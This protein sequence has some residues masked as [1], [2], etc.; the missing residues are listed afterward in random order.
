MLTDWDWNEVQNTNKHFIAFRY[1]VRVSDDLDLQMDLRSTWLPFFFYLLSF[2]PFYVKLY[3][4]FL[5]QCLQ[6]FRRW[7]ITSVDTTRGLRV[8][9]EET[10]NLVSTET[11][12]LT[13]NTTSVSTT[14]SI[15]AECRDVVLGHWF[16]PFLSVRNILGPGLSLEGQVT[17]SGLG[18][19]DKSSLTKMSNLDPVTSGMPRLTR[20]REILRFLLDINYF[21]V[22]SCDHTTQPIWV[23][24]ID[25]HGYNCP[26]RVAKTGKIPR[27]C[28]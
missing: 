9:L 4:H 26:I 5:S 25:N 16:W 14:V 3:K 21:T 2:C 12:G 13:I 27:E 1:N 15:A 11:S 6:L 20:N 23:P 7:F 10:H 17:D 24:V 19:E 18:L 28:L 22:E 8:L